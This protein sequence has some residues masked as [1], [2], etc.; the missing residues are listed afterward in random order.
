MGKIT[1]L[2]ETTIDPI[3]FMGRRAGICWG[4]DITDSEK[5][6]NRGLDSIKSTHGR[7]LEFVNIAAITQQE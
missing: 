2:P 4:A 6:Y 1:I 3:S 7:G 5:N